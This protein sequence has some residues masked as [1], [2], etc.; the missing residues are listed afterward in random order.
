MNGLAINPD[1]DRLL[2]TLLGEGLEG[3]D[4]ERLAG[5]LR[6]DAASRLIYRKYMIVDA[7]LRWENA[8]PIGAGGRWPTVSVGAEGHLPFAGVAVEPQSVGAAV[9]MPYQVGVQHSPFIIQTSPTIHYPL[10]PIHYTL[11]SYLMAALIFGAGL[12]I[13]SWWKVSAPSPIARQSASLSSTAGRGAEGEGEVVGRITGMADCKFKAESGTGLASGTRRKA[14]RLGSRVFFGDN[15]VLASGL[16]EITYSTGAK[17]ILQ[18]PVNYEVES[19]GGYL[20]VGK[21]TGKLEKSVSSSSF[22]LHPSS[23]TIHTP[24]AAVTDLGTEFGVEVAPHK[25]TQV[26]VLE[27]QVELR[28]SAAAAPATTL[29]K[30]QSSRLDASGKVVRLSAA[31]TANVAK[32]F[33][34]RL[35]RSLHSANYVSLTDLVAGGDGFG[36]RAFWGIDPRDATVMTEPWAIWSK[37]SGQYQRYNG[38][39]QIDGVFVPDGN[40]G[41]VQLDSAGHTFA[42]PKTTG[43]TC[44]WALWAY[45][46]KPWSMPRR[47]RPL[48]AKDA[49]WSSMLS[50]HANAGITFDLAAI[51]V[52]AGGRNVKCFQSTVH[53]CQWNMTDASSAAADVWVFVDGQ[54]RFSRTGLRRQSGAIEVDIPLRPSDRFLTLVSTDGGDNI[55]YDNI[56]FLNPRI[57]LEAV[58]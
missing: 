7:L 41:P 39:P 21:L 33:V 22:I 16:L 43:M 40:F 25:F 23:F 48:D 13:G 6:T 56:C 15:F 44:E 34:R 51:R 4:Q 49:A 14:E 29:K 35:P 50:L 42:L 57:S 32:T 55:G 58:P 52:S 27:G 3:P 45:K 5:L 54:L 19:N 20:A 26:C 24:T 10:S 17:V 9:E 53:N 47:T 18:G 37:A 11:F 30:G 46:G 28:S 31:T 38:L 2:A 36:D 8:P 12:L 1:L